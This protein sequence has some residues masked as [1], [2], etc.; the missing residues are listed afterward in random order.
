MAAPKKKKASRVKPTW[1]R[2][3]YSHGYW[4]GKEKVGSVK[5]GPP[6]D[7]DGVYRW[8]AGNLAGQASTLEEAKR[9]VENAVLMGTKQLGLF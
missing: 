1:E 6:K 3:H 4:R 9:A 5:L 7:W 2:G 8:E